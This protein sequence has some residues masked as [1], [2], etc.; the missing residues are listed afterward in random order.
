MA[1]EW[2]A[3]SAI[4]RHEIDGL[5]RSAQHV[6]ERGLV[7]PRPVIKPVRHPAP[8]GLLI[9]INRKTG[10]QAWIGLSSQLASKGFEVRLHDTFHLVGAPTARRAYENANAITG[11]ILHQHKIC[12]RERRPT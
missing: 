9:G 3:G 6:S 12:A 11:Q 4:A 10:L 8:I 1:P 5:D 2:S 7:S